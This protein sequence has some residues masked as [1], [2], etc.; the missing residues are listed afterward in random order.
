MHVEVEIIIWSIDLDRPMQ[1]IVG[2]LHLQGRRLAAKPTLAIMGK[3]KMNLRTLTTIDLAKDI[4][5]MA[6]S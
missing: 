4:R 5:S 6:P 2:L 3:Q 1:G